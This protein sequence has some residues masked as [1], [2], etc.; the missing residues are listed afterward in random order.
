MAMM[1]NRRMAQLRDEQVT[2]HAKQR[3]AQGMNRLLLMLNSGLLRDEQI[4][5]NAKQKDDA[6]QG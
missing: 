6:A 5:I 2:I 4:T 3:V 1:V